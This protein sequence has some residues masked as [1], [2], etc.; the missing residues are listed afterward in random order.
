MR[1]FHGTS[2]AGVANVCREF[3]LG[4]AGLRAVWE[5]EYVGDFERTHAFS[6]ESR[7]AEDCGDLRVG[8]D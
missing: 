5:A 3:E 1:K 6:V 8:V 7:V 4:A 2:T